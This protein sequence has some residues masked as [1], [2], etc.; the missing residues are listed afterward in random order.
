MLN[1]KTF[2]AAL[3]LADKIAQTGKILV[4][5]PNTVL[6]E[7]VKL[8]VPAFEFTVDTPEALSNYGYALQQTVESSMDKP[9]PYG[10]QLDGIINDLSKAV[11]NHVSYAKNTV[12]PLVLEFA[13]CIQKYL[14][15]SVS[16]D[17]SEKFTIETL[18]IPAVLKDDSFLDSLNAYKDKSALVPDL[19][20]SLEPKAHDEL[21]SMI[22]TGSKR[23]D[24]AIGEWIVTKDGDFLCNIWNSHFTN[25]PSTN[26]CD[27]SIEAQ[28]AFD[29]ADS[30]L[31]AYL[32]ARKIFEDVQDTNMNL[33]VY[34]NTVAQIRDYHGSLL[35]QAV[36][37][38][39]LFV[40]A[41]T[42]II[43]TIGNQYKV[44]VNGDIYREWLA[45]G[46]SPEIILGCLISESSVVSQSLIDEKA[47]E[48]K[49]RWY[50]FNSFYK[51]SEANKKFTYFKEFLS[52][53]FNDSL[54]TQD[55][56]E[57]EYSTKNPNYFI[58][59]RKLA[60]CEIENLRT[61]DMTDVYGVAL[62][63]VAK[64]RFY[65]TS[66]YGILSDI[67]EASKANPNVDVREAALLAVI[68]YVSD[69]LADQIALAA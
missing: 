30:A 21:C 52:N 57:K 63:L 17:G 50:S 29:K 15:T 45:K 38:I 20:L 28:N 60:D 44:K 6:N 59:A 62:T 36:T 7:L 67:N 1:N 27:T 41:R 58:G 8:S 55:D 53:A 43:E 48:F 10:L 13:T 19:K 26:G 31:A 24:E 14:D 4:A 47:E 34:K 66:S 39:A 33:T 61:G 32:M 5:K 68:N 18:N 40:K 12:K 56:S 64:C 51:T 11:N 25:S 65:Y 2:N 35:V 54:Q 69:Y 9:S 42:L 16:K 49:K 22:M 23:T 46:G 37:K 3:P